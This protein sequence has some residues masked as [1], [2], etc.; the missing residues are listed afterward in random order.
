MNHRTHRASRTLPEIIV[1]ILIG[2]AYL[3]ASSDD[4]ATAERFAEQRQETQATAIH[5]A[6]P[7]HGATSCDFSH[8]QRSSIMQMNTNRR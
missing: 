6:R 3:W 4:L 2:V 1:L 5:N 8:K 7:C